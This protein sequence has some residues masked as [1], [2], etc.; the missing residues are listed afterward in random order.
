MPI[1][2]GFSSQPKYQ[3]ASG[4]PSRAMMRTRVRTLTVVGHRLPGRPCRRR[5]SQGRLLIGTPTPWSA[6]SRTACSSR[7]WKSSLPT[8]RLVRSKNVLVVLEGGE[9]RR[10]GSPPCA[11]GP[12]GAAA[13]CSARARSTPARSACRA[14]RT[15]RGSWGPAS[16]LIF[17]RAPRKSYRRGL[18]SLVCWSASPSSSVNTTTPIAARRAAGL[19]YPAGDEPRDQQEQQRHRDQEVAHLEQLAVVQRHDDQ[20]HDRGDRGHREDVRLARAAASE[21]Q[22]RQQQEQRPAARRAAR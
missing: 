16:S 21:Q 7:R 12:P 22:Q 11:W 19:L 4:S 17:S 14:A 3:T 1:R 5:T 20:E 10:P 2:S 8:T 18:S 9:R 13:G 15:V 6:A